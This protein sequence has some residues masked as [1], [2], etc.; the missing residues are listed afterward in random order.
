MRVQC[1]AIAVAAVLAVQAA[2]SKPLLKVHVIPHTHDD[3]GWL[4][5]VDQYYLGLRQDIQP[6][7]VQYV[8]D[9]VV[10]SLAA[11]PDRRFTYAEMAF[12]TRWWAQQDQP[13]RDL[14]QQLVTDGRL[15]FAEGGCAFYDYATCP[16][17]CILHWTHHPSWPDPPM[18]RSCNSA[19]AQTS[20]PATWL[21]AGTCNTTR[22]RLTSSP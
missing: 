4:K 3:A 18:Q 19:A 16:R 20:R 21:S 2:G 11:S 8:L 14:V 5:T 9:T 10:Q 6:A 15:A 13:T 17:A 12:F 22:Q 7:A 1:L